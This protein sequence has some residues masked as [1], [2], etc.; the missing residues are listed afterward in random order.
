MEK[1]PRVQENAQRFGIVVLIP[2]YE[3]SDE[4]PRLV[5]LLNESFSRIVIV[6]DGS[7]RGLE[8]FDEVRPFV[9][10]ILVHSAN[11]GKGAA[12]KTALD[13]IG[14]A[15]VITVDADGQHLVPDIVRVAE[16]MKTHREGLTLGVRAFDGKV[17]LRSRFGNWWTRLFFF[18]LT[19]L[20]VRDT[21]TGLR[22]IPAS[23]IKRVRALPGE[24]Y[25]YEMVMLAD[26]KRHPQRPLQI[27]IE[28]VY[29]D[30]N[31]ESHF[32]PL[33]DTIRIYSALFGHL[34]RVR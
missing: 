29:I 31:S 25:E 14:D 22:G 4:L 15:D 26:A 24:R 18:L 6:N 34:F 13:Y 10:K 7:T 19:G 16:A 27:P 3:P 23:M 5:R 33:K 32:S 20:Y 17:P 21:Q 12:I 2:A 9:E 30:N 1:G 11:R 28:T 8:Y